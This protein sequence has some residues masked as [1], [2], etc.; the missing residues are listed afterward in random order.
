[1]SALDV[2]PKIHTTQRVCSPKARRIKGGEDS[3]TTEQIVKSRAMYIGDGKP[4]RVSN[5]KITP[6]LRPDGI[7]AV[8]GKN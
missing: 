3:A 7:R 2:E 1:M 5:L 8:K 6:Y 4:T